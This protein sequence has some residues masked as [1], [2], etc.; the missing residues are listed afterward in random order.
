MAAKQVWLCNAWASWAGLLLSCL[1]ALFVMDAPRLPWQSRHELNE[2]VRKAVRKTS[3][4][5][6]RATWSS[7]YINGHY[8]HQGAR[9]NTP[10][11]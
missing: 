6:L 7:R 8:A 11:H 1:A 10:E 3:L 9:H 2:A 5:L 4:Q